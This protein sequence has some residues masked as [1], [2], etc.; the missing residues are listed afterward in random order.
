MS[1]PEEVLDAR[2]EA[3]TA[4]RRLNHAMFAHQID[5]DQLSDL[6]A[7]ASEQAATIEGAPPREHP[8][9][10]TAHFSMPEPRTEDQGAAEGPKHLFSDSF[11]SGR[12][13]PMGMEASLWKAGDEAIMEVVLGPAFEGAPGRAHGGVMAAMS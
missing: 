1:T 13:N 10:G 6:A 12:A 9:R 4:L 2:I 8:F 5:V 3:A 7:R 11:V